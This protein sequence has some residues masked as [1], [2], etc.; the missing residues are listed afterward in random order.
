MKLDLHNLPQRKVLSSVT[1]KSNV[2]A[3]DMA[4]NQE[5]AT[6]FTAEYWRRICPHLTV[7]EG[8]KKK[9][10]IGEPLKLN[11]SL[12]KSL[13]KEV[14]TEGYFQLPGKTVE[15][16]VSY[17]GESL[18]SV[19]DPLRYP[20]IKASTDVCLLFEISHVAWCV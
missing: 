16:T 9:K 7:T 11:K 17:H 20:P 2:D 14:D 13:K 10:K 6:M 4:Q 8:K 19:F 5:H 12:L 15:S 3:N 18:S 1:D